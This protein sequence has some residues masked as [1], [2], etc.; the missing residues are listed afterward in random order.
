MQANPSRPRKRNPLTGLTM[1]MAGVM[2][3]GAAY[4]AA[5]QAPPLAQMD[6]VLRSV[7]RG[8]IARI[9]GESVPSNQY[10]DM[11]LGE[12]E[13]I[14][15]MQ[16]R[17]LSQAQR[18]AI[19]MRT[20]GMLV[21]REVMVR[22]AVLRGITVTDNELEVAWRKEIE[23]L[24]EGLR[25]RG[26]PA[27]SEE[28]VLERAGVSRHE[29]MQELRTALI[30]DR[31]Q[32]R[33]VEE[34][35][36]RVD[37]AEVRRRFEENKD[38]MRQPERIHVQQIFIAKPP[39]GGSDGVAAARARAEAALQRIRAGQR[40]ETVARDASEGVL[41]ERGGDPG[42]MPA[43]RMPPFMVAAARA[44]EP[45]DVSEVLESDV[46]FHVIRLQE[47]LHGGE[48]DFEKVREQIRADLQALQGMRIAKD[49]VTDRLES[50]D[51][52]IRTY[53]DIDTQLMAHPDVVAEL[54]AL[55]QQ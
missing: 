19:G 5:A 21:E 37:D 40:F 55:S 20:L 38:A 17:P 2:A 23:D 1:A 54:Q 18:V 4:F 12:V 11:Y 33:L 28:E 26:L 14:E 29:A 44:M 3:L 24:S 10:I 47:I 52:E 15:R 9:N 27:P 32:N 8:P 35:N 43:D 6:I 50:G 41:A 34:A 36:V 13:M 42:P 53:L 45:G 16:N 48:P 39:T 31:L 25:R 49:F 30:V 51:Y 7:P 22:E 46:G